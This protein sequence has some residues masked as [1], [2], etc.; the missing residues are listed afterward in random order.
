MEIDVS[1]QMMLFMPASQR[2]PKCGDAEGRKCHAV[3]LVASRLRKFGSRAH[4]TIPDWRR[5]MLF[6]YRNTWTVVV[7]GE[8]RSVDTR[9]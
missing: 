5:E 9:Q 2:P 3:P 7:L 6:R 8:K 4:Q 1:F